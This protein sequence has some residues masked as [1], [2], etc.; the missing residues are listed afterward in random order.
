MSTKQKRE[1]TAEFTAYSS[2]HNRTPQDQLEA[3]SQ[4]YPGGRMTGF[5]LWVGRA[6]RAFKAEHPQHWAGD[7]I[8]N[9]SAKIR[10]LQRY[11][12]RQKEVQ[13]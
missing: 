10:Y 6:L 3:D 9:H 1:F 13:S 11:A 4:E 5:I 12:K 7:N 8:L 2:A